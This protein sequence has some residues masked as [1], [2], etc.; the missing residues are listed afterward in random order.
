MHDASC[1]NATGSSD[2]LRRDHAAEYVGTNY[3]FPCSPRWLAKLAVV[4]GGP[5]FRKAGRTVLYERADLD[6]WAQSRVGPKQL[7]TADHFPGAGSRNALV[8]AR[9]LGGRP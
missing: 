7:S 1:S 3:G 4:G 9:G 8:R 5:P 6:E 2:Y